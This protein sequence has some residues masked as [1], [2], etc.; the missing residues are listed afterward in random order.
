MGQNL[1]KKLDSPSH[2]VQ[3]FLN[4]ADQFQILILEGLGN[5]KKNAIQYIEQKF[6]QNYLLFFGSFLRKPP[7]EDSSDDDKS[8][9]SESDGTYLYPKC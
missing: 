1:I 7:G 9:E 2:C 5:M 3:S 8:S 6:S 4:F